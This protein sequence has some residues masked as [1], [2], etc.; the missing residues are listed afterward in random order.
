MVE[1]AH[2]V[3]EPEGLAETLQEAMFGSLMAFARTG[4]PQVAQLPQWPACRDG[5]E[6]TLI[7][8]DATTV[9]ENFDHKLV[10][11]AAEA[12]MSRL[13]KSMEEDKESLQH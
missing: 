9:A 2:G 13:L 8:D 4:N 11:L 1:Y 5:Q 7:L 12:M 10:P 6:F 3:T